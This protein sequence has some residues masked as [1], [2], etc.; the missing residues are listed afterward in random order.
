MQIIL[1]CVNAAQRF[2][3]NMTLVVAPAMGATFL[4]GK[5]MSVSLFDILGPITV[6][7]SSSH[8]AGAVRIGLACRMLLGEEIK[9]AKVTLYGSFA[10]TAKGHGTDKAVVGGLL[11]HRPAD[12]ENRDS[13]EIAKKIGM[14]VIFQEAQESR[15]HPNT[16][17]IEA[18]GVSGKKFKMRAA[19]VGGGSIVINSI[20]EF[21]IETPC[22]QDTLVIIHLDIA[23]MLSAITTVMSW[24]GYNISN[25]TLKRTKRNG[26]VVSIIETDVPVADDTVNM[27]RMT[28]N[29]NQVIRIPKF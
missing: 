27:L 2:W 5:N 29:V 11:G 20:N 7:P 18:E 12:I 19:S 3:N 4:R 8:T 28:K 14:K 26:E 24:A 17:K 10:E 9:T 23:G 25:M 22:N 16:V 13:L 21:T 6:G 1:H 15:Y